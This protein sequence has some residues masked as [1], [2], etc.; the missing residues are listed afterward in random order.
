MG[1]RLVVASLTVVLSSIAQS[2][3]AQS[4]GAPSPRAITVVNAWSRATAPG[5][6]VGAAYFSIVNSGAADVLTTIETPLA[7][8]VEMHSV[9]MVGGMM[10]MRQT[11][12]LAIPAR[13]RAVFEPG[14]LHAMLIDLAKPLAAGDRVP[15]TLT[16][17]DAGKVRVD[18]VVIGLDATPPTA[19]V[20]SAGSTNVAPRAAPP[21]AAA[22]APKV[23]PSAPV[24]PTATTPKAAPSAA[25][26]PAFASSGNYRLPVWPAHAGSPD[27]KLIDADG[28]TRT[29]AD[30]RGG[31]V[32]VFFGFTHCPDAC[33]AELFKLGL[34]MKQLGP[35][36]R[37][38]QVLFVT[39]DPE[40]DTQERMKSYVTAFDPRFIGLTGTRDQVDE[41]ARSFYV[42][43]ARVGRGADYT[44][45]HSTSTF[46][47]DADG[48]LRLV[49]SLKTSVGDWTHDLAVLAKTTQRFRGTVIE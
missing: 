10:Q 27:F 30:Y 17:R 19:D 13:G 7:K 38:V 46:V 24:A 22:A 35:D 41:A 37:R 42:E 21:A 28:R 15:L 6:S 3:I 36:A 23:A 4:P 39:L 29:L 32:V 18:A 47:F 1:S 31:I 48:R 5:T 12:S 43:Y 8:R 33:P 49:G 9:T 14:T 40:R 45:D 2:S 26:A 20:S 16:F 25:A 11:S 34:A 44:I